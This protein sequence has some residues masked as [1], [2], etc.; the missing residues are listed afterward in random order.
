[1]LGKFPNQL[2]KGVGVKTFCESTTLAYPVDFKNVRVGLVLYNCSRTR[3]LV[4]N[5]IE[6]ES[7]H[8]TGRRRNILRGIEILCR[9]Q[10]KV[11]MNLHGIDMMCLTMSEG[12][13]CLRIANRTVNANRLEGMELELIAQLKTL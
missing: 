2:K 3:S 5:A 6:H 7:R 13:D 11:R 12:P 8:S 10:P 1:M 4:P 9:K